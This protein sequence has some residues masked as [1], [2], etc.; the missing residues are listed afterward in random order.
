M[1]YR[2]VSSCFLFAAFPSSRV[3][4][5]FAAA[6]RLLPVRR[7]D[8]RRRQQQFSGVEVRGIGGQ[9]CRGDPLQ[10]CRSPPRAD[11]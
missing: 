9:D 6:G 10:L 5:F 8:G 7:Q 1:L 4:F 2:Q 3:T 11:R